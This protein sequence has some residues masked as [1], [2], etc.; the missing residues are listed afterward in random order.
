M[1]DFLHGELVRKLPAEATVRVAGIGF[2]VRIPLSTYDVLPREGGEV[3]LL[4]HL[5]VR[6][7]ELSLYGFATELERD[8]FRMLLPVNKISTVVALRVL[9]S[10]SPAQFKR[11]ILDEDVDALKS[12]V[13]GVGPK[14]ARRMILELQAPVKEL[15][16]AEA[17]REVDRLAAD[18]IR[19][20]LTLGETR[21]A[22]EKSVQAAIQR[23]GPDATIQ[24][25]VE[26]AVSN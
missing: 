22:A 1:L 16:V 19:A 12:M 21:A 26:A 10:C 5:H 11:Y 3:T 2:L 13:K 14:T 6:E 25:L 4:T 7:D 20:L 24:Q 18:A 8:L 17:E 9:S 23:L 15:A